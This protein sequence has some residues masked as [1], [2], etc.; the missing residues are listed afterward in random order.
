[1]ARI[2]SFGDSWTAGA[3]LEEAEVAYGQQLS[4]LTGREL[5]DFG[6]A[7]NSTGKITSEILTKAH[8]Q[9]EDFVLICLPPDVRW[10]GENDNG[11]FF[12][13]HSIYP[14]MDTSEI[15]EFVLH[16]HHFYMDVML[17]FKNWGKY[18]FNL[19][20]FSIQSY[21]NSI[22][23]NYLFFHNYGKLATKSRFNPVID[24]SSFLSPDSLTT[25]LGGEDANID[26]L[27]LHSDG[28]ISTRDISTGKHF[29]GNDC[30]PNHSGHKVIA[31]LIYNNNKFQKWLKSTMSI[32]NSKKLL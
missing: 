18:H 9:A 20:L 21:L 24:Y 17:K 30:H 12:S 26:S 7:G 15:P 28:P 13:L 31:D 8:I 6:R 29:F 32:V 22:D 11:E 2:V 14:N 25:L 10:Y 4:E 27:A 5:V 1:M 16:Q 3:E 23:V 19:F